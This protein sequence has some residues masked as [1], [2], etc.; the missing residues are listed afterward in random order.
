MVYLKLSVVMGVNWLFEIVSF[1]F[2]GFKGWYISDVYNILIGFLIFLIF[3]CKKDIYRKLYKRYVF[4][5]YINT[6]VLQNFDVK[7][8]ATY[9]SDM[10]FRY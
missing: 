10:S 7:N 1:E 5:R 8:N 3:V 4:I 6:F 2:P 9:H